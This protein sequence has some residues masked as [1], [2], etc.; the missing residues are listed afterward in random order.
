MNMFSYDVN[1]PLDDKTP[2]AEEMAEILKALL[3]TLF[4][5]FNNSQFK[6][7]DDLCF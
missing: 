1:Y 7:L 2:S 5:S 6:F 4:T 3:Q